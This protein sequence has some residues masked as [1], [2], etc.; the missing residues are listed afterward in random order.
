MNMAAGVLTGL[1]LFVRQGQIDS[2]NTYIGSVI[3]SKKE[4][5]MEVRGL[6]KFTRNIV[7][8]L[9]LGIL[10]SIKF[11]AQ[12]AALEFFSILLRILL[13][14][15]EKLLKISPKGAIGSIGIILFVLS[16][17]LQLWFTFK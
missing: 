9:P 15:F 12:L 6:L 13:F 14:P 11:Y 16:N 3:K 7:K 5:I 4:N 10:F 1:E 17:A 2:I 8:D